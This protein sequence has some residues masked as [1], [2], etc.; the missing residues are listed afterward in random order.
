M[1]MG[2]SAGVAMHRVSYQCPISG[3]KYNFVTSLPYMPPGLIAYLYKTRWD[4]EKIFDEVK[5][6]LSE[7]KAWTTSQTAKTMQAQFICSAHNLMLIFERVLEKNG[8]ENI[9]ENDRRQA[10]LDKT[11]K[12]SSRSKKIK[13]PKFLTK[14]KHAAQRSLKFIRWL[15]NHLYINISWREALD[16][17]KRVYAVF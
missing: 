9:K 14:P 2:C 3:K 10:G 15:R 7:K 11:L 12:S 8:I 4:I 17:L 1:K 6:K 13:L 16:S 5:N